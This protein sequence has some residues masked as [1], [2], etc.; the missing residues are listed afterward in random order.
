MSKR[1]YH[2]VTPASKIERPASVT[3]LRYGRHED[4]PYEPSDGV[5]WSFGREELI[6]HI[7][8][9]E[10]ALMDLDAEVTPPGA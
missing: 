8:R 9:C 2:W 3:I 1:V 10:E 4:N 6:A 7:A 5:A